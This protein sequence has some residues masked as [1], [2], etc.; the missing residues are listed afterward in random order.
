[1]PDHPQ[2]FHRVGEI[3]RCLEASDVP[4]VDRFAVEQL[5]H[6]QRRQAIRILSALGG[7]QLGRTFL[8]ERETVITALRRL[9]SEGRFQQSSA[10]RKRIW[11]V[12]TREQGRLRARAISLPSPAVGPPGRSLP[13]GVAMTA[14]ELRVRFDSPIGLLERLMALAEAAAG[15]YDWF[16]SLCEGG[17]VCESEVSKRP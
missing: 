11:S 7:Y 16:E 14:G 2:W 8:V 15:D 9:A 3:L 13:P 17:A 1:M 10:Q 12:I 6:V 5:F 4:F